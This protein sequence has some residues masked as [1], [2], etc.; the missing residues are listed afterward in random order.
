MN[1][2]KFACLFALDSKTNP[3]DTGYHEAVVKAHTKKAVFEVLKRVYP[4]Y[5]VRIINIFKAGSY[6]VNTE[7]DDIGY[8]N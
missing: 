5:N 1:I 6:R 4:E 3:E 8:P 7:I 2:K